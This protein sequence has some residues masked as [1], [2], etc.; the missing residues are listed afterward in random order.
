MNNN[1]FSTANVNAYLLSV[2]NSLVWFNFAVCM[3]TIGIIGVTLN[4]ANCLIFFLNGQFR[5]K[6]MYGF[7][8]WAAFFH[9][10]AQL[11]AI[12]NS[13]TVISDL[14]V[15]CDF[16]ISVY[17]IAFRSWVSNACTLSGLLCNF[18]VSFIRNSKVA[19]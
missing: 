1:S 8:A 18:A 16:S 6:K 3:P 9:A 11:I 15:V 4:T 5:R 10:A 14:K 17:M 7:L 13:I 2:A 12:F 19:K